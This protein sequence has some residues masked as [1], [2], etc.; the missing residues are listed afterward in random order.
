M[1]AAVQHI[2]Q[3]LLAR[4]AGERHIHLNDLSDVIGTQA[5]TQDEID[6]VITALEGAGFRVGEEPDDHDVEVMRAVLASARA[7]QSTLGRK[8]SVEEIANHARRPEHV[9]RRA[10]EAVGGAARSKPTG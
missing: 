10:L 8:P 4:H 5:I 1:R 3:T 6:E 7:L 9:V 2:L